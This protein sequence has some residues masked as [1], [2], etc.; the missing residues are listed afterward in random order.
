M[1]HCGDLFVTDE[2]KSIFQL[3]MDRKESIILKLFTFF[4]GLF[5]VSNCFLIVLAH[6]YTGHKQR[7]KTHK[8]VNRMAFRLFRIVFLHMQLKFNLLGI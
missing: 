4:F 6:T 3:N 8:H 7:I 5:F 1:S 2:K